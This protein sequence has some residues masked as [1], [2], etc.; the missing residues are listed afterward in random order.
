MIDRSYACLVCGLPVAGCAGAPRADS[1]R[2]SIR[3]SSRAGYL[4]SARTVGRGPRFRPRATSALVARAAQLDGMSCQPASPA[5]SVAHVEVFAAGHVV[6][7]PPGIGISP[8]LVRRGAYVQ[9][10]RCAYPLRTVEP[11]GLVLLKAGAAKT[12]GQLFA[13]WGQPLSRQGVAGFGASDGRGVSV[14][15]DGL[16]WPGSPTDAR[17]SAGVQI[18]IEVGPYVRPHAGYSFPPPQ[19]IERRS[20]SSHKP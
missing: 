9:G 17:I 2:D 15:S 20:Q 12:L 3:S 13:L 14:F 4:A 18:T 1:I 8:P 6:V 11:T 5:A 16:L 7:I 19:A 10:G